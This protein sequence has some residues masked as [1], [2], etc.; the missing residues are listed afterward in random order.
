MSINLNDIID[1]GTCKFKVVKYATSEDVGNLRRDVNNKFDLNNDW[2]YIYPNN[3]TEQNP[4]NI[5]TS[6]TYI[7]SNPFPGY[8]VKCEVEVYY[9][10]KW[11]TAIYNGFSYSNS[12]YSNGAY[13]FQH[14]NDDLVLNTGEQS[15]LADTQYKR[16]VRPS[17]FDSINTYLTSIPCRVKVWKIGKI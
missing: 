6:S 5:S 1:Y 7:L 2:C 13:C 12:Y 4:A 3:G 14:D 15:I 17:T 10:N 11:G 16:N 9:N 8:I